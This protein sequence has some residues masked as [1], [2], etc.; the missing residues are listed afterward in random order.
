M[1]T[2]GSY[3]YITLWENFRGHPETVSFMQFSQKIDGFRQKGLLE[4][5]Q[6]IREIF[7][8]HHLLKLYICFNLLSL[9]DMGTLNLYLKRL[10][11]V[12][13]TLIWTLS[14]DQ[15]DQ[16]LL[17]QLDVSSTYEHIIT[18]E[19][20][21]SSGFTG[22]ISLDDINYL[23]YS[24][25][26]IRKQATVNT[27]IA[28]LM[29]TGSYILYAFL[30]WDTTQSTLQCIITPGHWIHISILH[31]YSAPSQLPGEHSGNAPLQGRTHATSSDK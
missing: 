27:R 30:V 25:A 9:L 26:D 18:F 22:D 31:S 29:I 6:P 20:I 21:D 5:I 7:N 17:G 2:R 12:A 14:G 15:G 4:L 19:A 3:V 13:E 24:C 23:P 28:S 11:N 10:P 1:A 16:W 8:F